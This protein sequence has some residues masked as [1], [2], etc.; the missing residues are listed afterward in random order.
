MVEVSETEPADADAAAGAAAFEDAHGPDDSVGAFLVY[1]LF[2]AAIAVLSRL[3]WKLCDLAVSAVAALAHRFDKRH[4]RAAREFLTTALGELSED[5]LERRVRES[6]RH[7][8]R[9]VLESQR[10]LLRVER[11]HVLEHFDLV[12]FEG[13]REALGG[14]SG[15]VIVGCHLGNWEVAIMGV[16]ALGLGDFWGIAKPVKNRFISRYIYRSRLERGVHILPRR[17]AMA[18]APAI[19]EGGDILGMLLD[20]RARVKPVLAPFFGRPARCD[21]SVGV[22]LRRLGA[23][24]VFAACYRIPERPLHYRLE[25]GPILRPEDVAGQRPEAIS[26]RINSELERKILAAP[27]Q[28]FWLHDRY[29]DAP[30]A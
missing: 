17:G 14:E 11:G 30:P 20:Q 6:Y 7:F 23:P 29:R 4:T 25:L 21:R 22:L 13:A 28:Y 18:Q 27:E 19:V 3:P 9:V 12:W 26:A 24:V 1:L 10:F 16:Q 2:R 8:F 5:E 15:A